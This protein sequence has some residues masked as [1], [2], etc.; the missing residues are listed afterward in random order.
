VRGLKLADLIRVN[1]LVRGGIDFNGFRIWYDTLPPEQRRELTN[2]LCELAHQA[3]VANASWDEALAASGLSAVDPAVQR[4]WSARRAE[5]PVFPLCEFVGAVSEEDLPTVFRLFVYLFGIAEGKVFQ[6][7][8]KEWCNHWWH[9]DLLDERVV[10]DLLRDPQF[11]MTAMKDD[12][13]IKTQ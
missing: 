1:Q 9:R 7:E 6:G 4:L 13:R 10:Q 12:D 2:L 5:F 8:S 11:Y 3:G